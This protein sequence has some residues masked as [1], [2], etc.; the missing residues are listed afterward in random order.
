MGYPDS[1]QAFIL[2]VGLNYFWLILVSWAAIPSLC[3]LHKLR[4]QHHRSFLSGKDP[5][6]LLSP[7]FQGMAYTGIKSAVL[8]LLVPCSKCEP[9]T[10]KNM[11]KNASVSNSEIQLSL[12]RSIVFKSSQKYS[13]LLST[14]FKI[15]RKVRKAPD[16]NPVQIKRMSFHSSQNTP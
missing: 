6:G 9:Y 11:P 10:I 8:M 4:S 5:Q 1:S 14:V 13:L 3:A 15:L 16:F 12:P 2:S 7:T